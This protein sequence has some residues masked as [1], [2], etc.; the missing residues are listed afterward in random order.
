MED[1]NKMLEL[2]ELYPIQ[3]ECMTEVKDI[4]LN[5]QQMNFV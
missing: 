1:L 3:L 2:S 5:V 4:V